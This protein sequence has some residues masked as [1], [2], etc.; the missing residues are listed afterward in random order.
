MK[1][2]IFLFLVVG[3]FI[4][5]QAQ[6]TYT[7]DT[8]QSGNVISIILSGEGENISW[9]VDGV[10]SL[11]FKIVWSKNSGPT[12][13]LRTGDKY[14][15]YNDP[16]KTSDQITP[17]AGNG[18]YYVRVCEYLGGKCGVYSNE[19]EVTLG[20]E[21]TSNAADVK[22]IIL[23][24]EG[25][26]IKWT[27][28][29]YSTQGFKV[30]WSKNENPTYPCRESDQ[31]HFYTNANASSD[32]VDA[33]SGT[34]DYYV[35][36]CEYLGGK[37]GV[38]SNEIKL[39]LVEPINIAC[40]NIGMNTEGWY[41]K[42]SGKLY[43]LK[44]CGAN[45]ACTMDYNPV[46]GKDGKTYSNKCVAANAGA[47]ISY[48]GECEVCNIKCLKYD[49]VCGNNGKTFSCGA[50]EAECNGIKVAYTGECKKDI[51]II[52]IENQ[53]EKLSNNQLSEILAELKQLRDLVKEQQTE[54]KYL[55][56][57][58]NDM[59][60][61]TEKMQNAINNFITYGADDSTKKLGEGERAAVINSFKEAYGKLPSDEAE[62]ADAIKIANGR[63][64]SKISAEAETKA[65]EIFE[66]IY[67]READMDNPNDS[68]AITI[69]AY[70]LRQRAENRNLHSEKKGIEI[71]NDIF[72][73][74]P[75]TTEE[76]NIMQAITYSG[77]KR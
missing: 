31:Y 61:I 70:G 37:C 2:T 27:V 69:M 16:N 4:F 32:T 48:S 21:E 34:G 1:K 57:F 28:E 55:R 50:A 76:W 64:P 47:V 41:Y 10:S 25:N 71:F 51:Q 13:P 52:N 40:K 15:Y 5:G 73:H 65:K 30:V 66:R 6:A 45:Q 62:L 9:S 46:C 77:A 49:P 11:G 33:F 42:D 38:Y 24:G 23:T 7:N 53:A 43:Q 75:F 19:I 18:V 17:F 14:N 12:Y 26:T 29:G 3:L 58:L 54:L 56:K 20:T 35:R 44:K 74:V 36:V 67:N 60:K 72:G 8:A 59:N 39:V 68:A 22:S 63:W